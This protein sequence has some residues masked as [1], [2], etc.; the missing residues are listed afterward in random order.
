M[1]VSR[2]PR[3]ARS[4]AGLRELEDTGE[5]DD[6][7]AAVVCAQCGRAECPGC[8]SGT[9]EGTHASKVVAIVPWERPRSRTS[10]RLWATA[11]LS[12]LS[13]DSFFGALPEGDVL[14]A[15]RFAALAELCA[16]TGLCLAALPFIVALVP[17]LLP[18][19]WLDPDTRQSLLAG[20]GLGIPCMAAVM[21][22][23]HAVHGVGLDFG[24]R[25]HGGSGRRDRGLRFGFYSC[26]WDLITLPFGLAMLLFL[27]GLATARRALPLGLTVPGRATRAY[28][29]RGHGLDEASAHRI[30]R[31]AGALTGA[32]LL[33]ALVVAFG[34][35]L[36][37]SLHR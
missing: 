6:V 19:L 11:K 15:A 2:A 12:T 8:V 26:G 36:A 22:A 13:A 24:V 33:A 32:L 3:E 30:S 5:L 34:A 29:R 9:D 37:G 23:L 21:M 25:R 7:P 4:S 18:T 17:T 35:A 27:D 14:P 10:E 31:F 16:V 28:L 1:A 20:V